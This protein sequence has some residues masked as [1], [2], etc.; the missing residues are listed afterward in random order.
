[1]Y[2]VLEYSSWALDL[3]LGRGNFGMTSRWIWPAVFCFLV[4]EVRDVFFRLL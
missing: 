1:M 3:T 4:P 2:G